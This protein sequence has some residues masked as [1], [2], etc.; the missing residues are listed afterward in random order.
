[1]REE[2]SFESEVIGI[3]QQIVELKGRQFI[4]RQSIVNYRSRT[5]NL[6]DYSFRIYAAAPTRYFRFTLNHSR[7]KE[8]ALLRLMI[9]YRDNNSDVMAAPLPLKAATAPALS[10]DW[11]KETPLQGAS[12]SWKVR[13]I[14]GQAG[15]DY[16]DA[17]FKFFIEGTDSGTWTITAL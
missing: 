14:K 9:F 17:Y 11:R 3:E 13:V 15:I 4:G 5:N 1:M 2:S 12:T 7:A 6:S 16:Y 8:G 10:V